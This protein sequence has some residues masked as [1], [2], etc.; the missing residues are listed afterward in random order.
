MNQREILDRAMRLLPLSICL[1]EMQIDHIRLAIEWAISAENEHC[2]EVADK[3]TFN[4]NVN[5]AEI[6][7]PSTGRP[8]LERRML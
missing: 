1:D 6:S 3:Q 4:L 2:A 8:I 5:G 7:L